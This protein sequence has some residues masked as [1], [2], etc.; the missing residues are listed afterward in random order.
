MMLPDPASGFTA[1]VLHTVGESIDDYRPPGR[2]DG[3][4]AWPVDASTVRLLVTHELSAATGTPYQ[5]ANGTT[6]RGARVSYF[7]VDRQTRQV[8]RSGLA[9]REVRDRRGDI[10]TDARQ[11]NER[12][13]SDTQAGFASFCT[14][15]GFRAA[16]SPFVDDLFFVH[17]EVSAREDHPHGGSHWVLDVARQTLWG[18]PAL[19]R[20]SWE[21][22]ALVATPDG[23][24]PD[25]HIALLLGDDYEF[26]GAPL[27]LWIGR[28]N[29]AGDLPDRNGLRSGQLYAWASND[30]DVSPQTWN[31]AGARRQGRF[32]PLETRDA[33][34][35]GEPGYDADGYLDD[36]TLRAQA[37]A[38]G[39][40]LF[41]RPEDLHANPYQP[42]HVAFASTGHGRRYPADDWGTLYL[43]RM[44]WRQV[45]RGLQPRAEIEILYDGDETRDMGIRNP[46]NVVWAG[47]GLVYVQEDKSTKLGRFGAR[48]GREASVWR[49][50]PY[51]G[52]SLA[53]IAEM[54]RQAVLPAG[55]VDRRPDELGAWESSGILDV[56]YAFGVAPDE[57]LLLL[58]V[59]AH[60]V[61]GGPIGG[62]QD[63]VEGGQLL[64]LS[65]PR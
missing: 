22:V 58:T 49:I 28:K 50:D 63:L 34:R 43:I 15:A 40:F 35:A 56:S 7:D 32:I 57:L 30:G 12:G 13:D 1:Q 62:P 42:Y 45:D 14:A 52:Q 9:F 17:E 47:D 29:P 23:Q 54:N 20:A 51:R 31:G 65:R 33:G 21:N 4:S 6:L 26:G 3:T 64:L 41:S 55:A 48:S 59:Q 10:V 44:A 16:T 19:G 38:R 37:K 36:T 18:L 61:V 2:P 39:A 5:L 27:L 60:S 46:D 8:R 11:I 53:R 25:G 24:R